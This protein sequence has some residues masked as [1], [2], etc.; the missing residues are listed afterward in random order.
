M[1]KETR[2]SRASAGTSSASQAR[3]P[4]QGRGQVRG[5]SLVLGEDG[6]VGEVG[7]EGDGAGLADD[8]AGADG[9]VVADDAVG[10]DH[11]MAIDERMRVDL[12][13]V[14]HDD[15][16]GQD[17]ALAHLC[18]RLDGGEREYHGACPELSIAAHTGTR[19]HER[20]SPILQA[21]E[22]PHPPL[23]HFVVAE[24]HKSS[25]IESLQPFDIPQPADDRAVTEH[26]SQLPIIQ[27]RNLRKPPHLPGNLQTIHPMPT[28]TQNQ[29]TIHTNDSPFSLFPNR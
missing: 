4:L 2:K 14:V 28:G 27:E 23:P 1:E 20:K 5:E 21:R 19:A 13:V 24:R 25:R 16:G 10:A 8:A 3:R 17:A 11:R 22:L 29:Q 9:R 15:T 18:P 12:C 26:L 6:A 7:A